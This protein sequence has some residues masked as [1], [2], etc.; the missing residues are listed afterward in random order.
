[1]TI[2]IVIP[3]SDGLQAIPPE[4]LG[5]IFI[6]SFGL[7]LIAAGIYTGIKIFFY[8]GIL[9]IFVVAIL[10]I[11]TF[12][13]NFVYNILSAMLPLEFPIQFELR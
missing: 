2:T 1:M 9:L 5:S 4:F 13:S 11:I 6:V 12:Y 10:L 3:L 8:D 7:L